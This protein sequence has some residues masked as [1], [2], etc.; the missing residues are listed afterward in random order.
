VLTKFCGDLCAAE[1]FSAEVL[2]V[3]GVLLGAVFSCCGGGCWAFGSCSA[4]GWGIGEST[5]A[6]HF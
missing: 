1:P 5:P 2:G 3:L 6:A 4:L